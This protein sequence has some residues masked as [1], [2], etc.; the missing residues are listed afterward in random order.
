VDSLAALRRDPSRSAIVLDIDGTLA[1]IAPH[2]DLAGV[3]AAT[4][5]LLETLAG[6]YALVG[7]VS[8]RAATDAARL[9]PVAGLVI[10]GNHGLETLTAGRLHVVGDAAVW[11]PA[12]HRLARELVPAAALAGAWV[13]DKGAT[14]SIHYREA[15]DPDAAKA[16]LERDAVPQVRA[17]GLVARFGR[18]TLEVLPPVPVDKGSAVRR[19]LLHR[20]IATS[21]YAGDDT[22]DIDAF[23]VVDVAVAVRSAEMPPGL[24]EAATFAVD[25]TEGVVELLRALAEPNPDAE[26]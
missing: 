19:L 18:M 6:R 4:L 14:L 22:T 16:A 9:V 10:S 25:G 7:C 24:V 13:E 15:P 21:L 12:I 3:P 1:P 26:P 8:G 23:K 2:P 20:R 5:T 17:A 11:L